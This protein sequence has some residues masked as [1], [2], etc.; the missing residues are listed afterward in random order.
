MVFYSQIE[1]VQKKRVNLKI[2]IFVIQNMV[3]FGNMFSYPLFILFFD[4]LSTGAMYFYCYLIFTIQMPIS[5][6]P[7][8]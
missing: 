1:K 7:F 3:I 6:V 5:N 8:F 2:I 4:I